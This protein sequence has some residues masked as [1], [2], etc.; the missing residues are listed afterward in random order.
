M[1]RRVVHFEVIGKDAAKLQSFY[2]QL[3]DWKVDAGNSMSY[4]IV[5]PD[6]AGVGGGIGTG[7]EGYGGHVTVY[8]EVPD[9]EAALEQAESLGATRVMG[10]EEVME[11]VVIGMF[12]DPEGHVIGLLEGES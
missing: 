3:F 2:S 11:G 10:R 6:D 5:S 4:G 12:A 8:V 1:G 7:P 9:I